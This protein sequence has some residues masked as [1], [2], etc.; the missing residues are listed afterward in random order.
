MS[1]NSAIE[2]PAQPGVISGRTRRMAFWIGLGVVL[3]FAAGFLE[4]T[5]LDRWALPAE[6]RINNG[7]HATFFAV[8]INPYYVFSEDFHLY[9]VR[10]QRI[11]KR[12]WTDSPLCHRE[13]EGFNY[14]APL[15]VALMAVAAATEGRPVP[16]TCFIVSVLVLGWGTLY[17]SAVRWA[18]RGISPFSILVAV[19]VTVLFESIW[20]LFHWSTEYN[21]W[22]IHRGLRM[23]TLAW[24]S[25]LALAVLLAATSLVFSRERPT[26]RIVFITI[27][28]AMLSAADSWAFLLAAACVGVSVA[29]KAVVVLRY[30]RRNWPELR[31]QLIVA[32]AMLAAIGLG[33]AIHRATSGA[34]T[35][36][37]FTRAGFGPEWLN[38]PA[39]ISRSQDYWRASRDYLYLLG[40]LT[41]LAG[42][43]I[44]VGF[45]PNRSLQLDLSWHPPRDLRLYLL[46][47]VAIPSLAWILVVG[48][49]SRIGMENYHASQFVWR[50]D[51]MLLLAFIL[52][53]SE[54]VRWLLGRIAR[55]DRQ[56]W[57]Y[58]IAATV[59]VLLALFVFHTERIHKFVTRVAVREFF[60]TEDEELL[61]KWLKSYDQEQKQPY[62]L[63]TASHELN[64]LA[65]SWTNADL[66][67]PEGFPYHGVWTQDEI[68]E[69]TKRIMQ[70][71]GATPE[72]WREFN[73]N[74]HS[75]DQ[76]S[77]ACSRLVSARHGNTYYLLHRG[78]LKLGLHTRPVGSDSP[79]RTTK[80]WSDVRLSELERARFHPYRQHKEGDQM[81]ER[82]VKRLRAAP[83]LTDA[84]LPDV[85][86]IDEV[87][88]FLGTPDLS[89]YD[90]EFE[91][92]SLEAWVKRKPATPASAT[93]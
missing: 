36:D 39:G 80:Y 18:W 57:R 91:H 65:A 64:Y 50:R 15:Q 17:C 59:V 43:A 60:L 62:T 29:M 35:G 93:P 40:G 12:G 72:R 16:Y 24:T 74:S 14:T 86:I 25:P 84:D 79:G 56:W 11:L 33:L 87:S 92:G 10:S 71:Y 13:N 20:F 53:L 89:K 76:W 54:L 78:L 8:H 52:A 45:R 55:C 58:Q 75:M 69:R 51:Y 30:H 83:P 46:V 22:P 21:H 34:I 19:L 82:I 27:V 42:A 5:M 23:A 3:L 81:I 1:A 70:L 49:L 90:R 26:G 41:V 38:S 44:Q 77:W 73:L 48:A 67:L 7:Q 4:F 88:R 37:A 31:A 32:I 47:L 85:L 6:K 28:L 61:Q 66:L 9:V 2:P 63:A 68:E